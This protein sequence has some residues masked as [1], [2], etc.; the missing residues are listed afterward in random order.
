MPIVT[1]E[2]NELGTVACI[3]RNTVKHLS[4]KV[5][6]EPNLPC[7]VTTPGRGLSVFLGSPTLSADSERS[8]CHALEC[9][10]IQSERLACD[11]IYP[12]QSPQ[13]HLAFI[14]RSG[15]VLTRC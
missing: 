15:L 11:L 5:D 1:S 7:Y 13:E 4:T 10:A 12:E 3:L 2:R 6:L 9:G 8:Y 14:R